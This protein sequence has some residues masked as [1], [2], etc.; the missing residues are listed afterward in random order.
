MGG[1]R[2]IKIYRVRV[3][4]GVGGGVGDLASNNLVEGY[5]WGMSVS[6]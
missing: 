5:K 3:S 2:K 6:E 1:G 4:G